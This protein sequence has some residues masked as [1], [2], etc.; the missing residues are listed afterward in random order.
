MITLFISYQS[1]L[2]HLPNIEAVCAALLL[3]SSGRV[4]AGAMLSTRMATMLQKATK[5]PTSAAGIAT[6]R[7]GIPS[8][9]SL[10][11][12]PS[13]ARVSR[14]AMTS[15]TLLERFAVGTP[16]EHGSDQ[17][18]TRKIQGSFFA[19]FFQMRPLAGAK[20]AVKF[21]TRNLH[22]FAVSANS[23]SALNP[24]QLASHAFSN[25]FP[26]KVI[27]NLRRTYVPSAPNHE[28]EKT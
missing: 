16:H 23:S 14:S 13:H 21:R 25:L 10:T 3:E 9:T 26:L 1:Y 5:P 15:D 12:E 19:F 4:L 22:T 2:A 20:A 11:V 24:F 7:R 18:V 27:I 6:V 17:E 8:V 28:D